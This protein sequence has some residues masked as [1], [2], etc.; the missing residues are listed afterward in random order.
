MTTAR[1]RFLAVSIACTLCACLVDSS[2]A[3]PQAPRPSYMFCLSHPSPPDTSYFSGIFVVDPSIDGDAS[4][5]NA[6]IQ[7]ERAT[8]HGEVPLAPW[9]EQFDRYIA[10]RDPRTPRCSCSGFNTLAEAQ[11]RIDEVIQSEQGF[12]Y[13]VVETGWKYSTAHSV[14]PP[15]TAS[16]PAAATV[17][18][19]SIAP[20]LPAGSARTKATPS[21]AAAVA[22]AQTPYAVCRGEVA[23]N[24]PTAYFSVPFDGTAKNTPAWTKSYREALNSKYGRASAGPLRCNTLKSLADAQAYLQTTIDKLRTTHKIIETGWKYQ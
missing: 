16:Q 22:P 1:V 2:T 3:K 11:K 14:A 20:A 13:K 17:A 15:A 19:V 24:N 23:G 7:R 9:V 21:A 8:C 6:Q 12:K 4:A 10:Q 18:P 5:W